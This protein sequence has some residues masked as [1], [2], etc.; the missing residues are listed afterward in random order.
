MKNRKSP[1]AKAFISI[2]LLII[3]IAIIFFAFF[4]MNTINK[5]REVTSLKNMDRSY[6]VLIIGNNENSLFLKQVYEGAINY[7]ALYNTVVE[8][9][10][11]QSHAEDI[12]PQSLF[13]YASF[14]NADGIIAYIDDSEEELEPIEKINGEQ[15]PTVTIGQFAANINQISYVGNSYWE[16]GQLFGK[17]II[18][19]IKDGGTVLIQAPRNIT[20]INYSNLTNSMLSTIKN[21]TSFTYSVLNNIDEI[22]LQ[23]TKNDDIL[24][25]G[26]TEEDTIKLAQLYNE[27]R[28]SK[29]IGIIGFGNNETC[30]SYLSKGTVKE[31][32]SQNP[33]KV[34]EAAI[35]ALIEYRNKGYANSYVVSELL[36]NRGVK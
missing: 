7:S 29:N 3:T 11:P 27:T 5:S 26:L 28:T 4:F 8:L 10:V 22:T 15:I 30:Q 13:E 16:L 20:N 9:Y 35:R 36:I 2:S 17:E 6:H 1:D 12:S 34:G 33:K 23:S 18:S 24:M 32:I 21:Q 14:I 31:L 19:N 25:I